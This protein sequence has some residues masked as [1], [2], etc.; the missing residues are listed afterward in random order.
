MI[1]YLHNTFILCCIIAIATPNVVAQS[2]IDFTAQ[3]SAEKIIDSYGGFNHAVINM[4][5]DEWDIVRAWEGFDE[6]AYLE[7][8]SSFKA[9]FSDDRE[10][11]KANRQAKVL[12]S[13]CGCW[14]EPDATYTTLV[15]PP[16]LGGLQPGEEQWFSQGG[17]GD[18]KSVV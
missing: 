18:R 10:K 11:R 9:S 17:A 13:D 4:T 14:V 5:R 1:R 15:P 2:N 16:G 12:Q 7:T 3:K 8:L 6:N